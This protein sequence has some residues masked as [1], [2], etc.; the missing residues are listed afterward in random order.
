MHNF[1]FKITLFGLDQNLAYSS[2]ALSKLFVKIIEEAEKCKVFLNVLQSS[3]R[4]ESNYFVHPELEFK[5]D[6]HPS[7]VLQQF[8]PAEKNLDKNMAV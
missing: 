1:Y 2:I 8:K 5:S 3:N 7:S 6:L 4:T